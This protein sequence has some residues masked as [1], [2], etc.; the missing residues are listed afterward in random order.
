MM[1]RQDESLTQLPQGAD[2]RHTIDM[3]QAKVWLYQATTFFCFTAA[4]IMG[5][6]K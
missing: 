2:Y 4:A 3:L 5:F 1:S 6:S